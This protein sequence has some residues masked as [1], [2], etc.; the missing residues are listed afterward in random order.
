MRFRKVL[1]LRGPNVWARFPVLE[2]WVDLEELKDSP[3]DELP[4]FNERLMAWLPSLIE[5][6]CSLGVRG[7]FFE[8]LRRGTYQAHI[9]E[10]VTLELQ[11][12]AGTEVG[13]GRARETVEEGV[14][15]VAI[16]YQEEELARDCLETA[17]RLLDA[18]VRDLPFDI[19]AELKRLR[20]LAQKVK[21]GPS[22]AAIVAAAQA[23]GIPFRRLNNDSLVMLGQGAR[24][25]RIVAA[26]T[27]QTPATSEYIAQD[28]Q[29]TRLLLGSCGIRVP[30][31]R[32]VT[33][34]EDAWAAAE[35]LGLPVVLK[36]Q[37]G[38]HGE[39][40]ATNLWTREQVVAA[41]QAARKHDYTY[42]LVEQ[43]IEGAD[44]RLLVVGGKVVAAAR[45]EPAQ[46]VGDGTA[47]IAALVARENEDPRRSDDHSTALSKIPLDEISLAVL[48][49]Q[50]YTLDT[51]PPVGVR[52]LI[53]RNANLS[54]GGTAIDVTDQV[55]PEVA[56]RAVE[57]AMIVGLDIAG[58]D[59]VARDIGRPLEEQQGAIVEVNAG[60]GLR[61]HLEP[62]VGT[63]RPVGEAIIDHLFPPGDNGRIPVVGVTG[64]NGKT[65]VTRL[66]AH[67]LAATGKTVG[68]TCTEGIYVGGRRI[69]AGDCSGPQSARAVLVN[70]KVEAAVLE[71]A[72]GGILRAGLGFDQ[73]DVAIVTNIGE[74]DHLGLAW[75]ET[76]EQLAYVKSTLVDVVSPQGAAVLN[77]ADPLV[78]GMA[79]LCRGEVIYFARD[80]EHPVIVQHRGQ[81]GRAVFPRDGMIILAHGARE[82]PFLS[83]ARVPLTHRGRISFQVENTLAGLAAA[84]ALEVP[85]ATLRTALESFNSTPELAP[86]RFNVLDAGGATVIIDYA[87]NPSALLALVEALEA[88]PHHRRAIVFAAAGDRRDEDI[89]RQ[90]IL[91]GDAFDR[92]YLYEDR[93]NRGRADGEVV[94]LLRRGVD[95][96]S[97][98]HEVFESRGEF[99][100]IETALR[101]LRP[102]DLLV[103]QADTV[104]EVIAFVRRTLAIEPPAQDGVVFDL[105][106]DRGI[107][108]TR[109]WDGAAVLLEDCAAVD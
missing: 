21:L 44:F 25:R 81:D 86:G 100:T 68:M 96:G 58:V 30:A 79:K 57:A 40:V 19:G 88:F 61:M 51:V 4:G 36:P 52:V 56:A 48:A 54:T 41:Y 80:G 75:I 47:T 70:P 53:R 11:S 38:H 29:V 60:P 45:R 55:H 32:A 16:E 72:R 77:A 62:S 93:C 90:G 69:E 101:D 71:T 104:E 7:G 33:S 94:A 106:T 49:E 66:V 46:V 64:V 78:A 27:N 39:C 85:L 73:C 13:F 98:V 14:Y 87:H 20:L 89:I 23:R 3:S 12:L 42:I 35:E 97:R 18:A 65:T 37:F 2:A 84:W 99:T 83:L 22:T 17:R 6:R 105:H 82:E 9:L 91:V 1:A 43:F 74:G 15:K 26:E 103:I 95:Q 109:V 24:Q 59:V 107:H 5:H 28:K 108:P 50:G 8:R 34:A 76:P 63:P 31:G 92:V 102:G 67:I 10:H